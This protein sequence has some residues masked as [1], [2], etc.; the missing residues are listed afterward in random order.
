MLKETSGV[1]RQGMAAGKTVE[2]MKTAKV[3]AAWQKWSGTF[4][5][6]D[7]WIETLYNSLSGKKNVGFTR[8]N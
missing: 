5:T 1:V 3:L 7:T 8:H 6:T 2:Q 4:I